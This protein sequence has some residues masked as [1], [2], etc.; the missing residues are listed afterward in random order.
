VAR[1]VPIKA[2]RVFLQ[3]AAA[4]ARC[5]ADVVF[6]LAGPDAHEGNPRLRAEPARAALGSRLRLL[7]ERRDVPLLTAALDVACL[8]S[9]S[10]G[11]PN[12]VGEAMACGVTCVVTDVG[13]TAHL[14]GGT[15]E[16]VPARDSEA[17]S[18]ALLR[19]LELGQDGRRSR[20]DA[21]RRRIMEHFTLADMVSR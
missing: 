11:F 2:H 19:V 15:G 8:T 20:G 3:A 21:A 12:V 4:V 10:E 7:G 6:L 9:L 14:L 13:D 16:V 5:R 1:Y 18:A 17:F